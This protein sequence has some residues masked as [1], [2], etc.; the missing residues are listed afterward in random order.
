MEIPERVEWATGRPRGVQLTDGVITLRHPTPD[1]AWPITALVHE[2]MPELQAWMAW[3]AP[4]YD[5][6]MALDW[7]NDKVE[8]GS[9]G[10]VVLDGTDALVG[11]IGIGPV[12]HIDRVTDLGY[13]IATAHTGHGFATRA[14]RLLARHAIETRYTHRVEIL[15]SVHNEASYRVAEKAGAHHEG[16]LRGRLFLHGVFHDAHAWSILPE[17]FGL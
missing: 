16:V 7:I 1:D 10:F 15:M 8:P 13:W 17:D 2:S 6:G 3:A 14:T 9:E 12:D 4:E 11:A 5:T